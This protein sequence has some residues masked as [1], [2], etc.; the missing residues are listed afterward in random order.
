[1]NPVRI[2]AKLPIWIEL[3]VIFLLEL[4]KSSVAVA[5]AVLSPKAAFNPGIVAYPLQLKGD[6][7]IAALANM[8]SLTPGTT[9]LHVTEDRKTLYIH[10]LDA[11]SAEDVVSGIHEVFEKRLMKSEGIK[12]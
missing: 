6:M 4:V 2:L 5:R 8:I 3:G 11:P 1:M 12:P 7:H 10:A 9:S